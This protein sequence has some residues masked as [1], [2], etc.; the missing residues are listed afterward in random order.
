MLRDKI[1]GNRG[2]NF[3]KLIYFRTLR[4]SSFLLPPAMECFTDK[5]AFWATLMYMHPCIVF[6]Q[7]PGPVVLELVAGRGTGRGLQGTRRLKNPLWIWLYW[8]SGHF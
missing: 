2:E 8:L 1:S 5:G 6:V 4:H 3:K 7:V